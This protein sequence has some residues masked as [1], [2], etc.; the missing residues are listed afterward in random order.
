VRAQAES[1]TENSGPSEPA[2]DPLG[3]FA[4]DLGKFLGGVQ[5]KA[6]S[7]LQQR[8]DIAEQL[9][10]I[11]DTANHYL[12]QLSGGQQVTTPSML[13]KEV[14]RREGQA[15]RGRPPGSRNAKPAAVPGASAPG[16]AVEEPARPK[17]TM[18]AEARA[19]IADAQ[20]KRWAKVRRGTRNANR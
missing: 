2:A 12:Q 17:R 6:T 8:K 16:E 1:V 19:R 3:D 18:S 4:A 11:R 13:V 14:A 7:W 5:S 9:T 15:R 10:R 20:R